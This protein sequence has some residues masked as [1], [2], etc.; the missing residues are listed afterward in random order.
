MTT[1]CSG[2]A[3]GTVNTMRSVA[4]D[5]EEDELSKYKINAQLLGGG[6]VVSEDHPDFVT[7]EM[8]GDSERETHNNRNTGTSRSVELCED[9]DIQ[10]IANTEYH[11]GYSPLMTQLAIQLSYF[12]LGVLS[13]AIITYVIMRFF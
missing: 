9:V 8:L 1:E 11:S 5:S 7:I 10:E 13:G 3:D 2:M 12:I 6:C 4:S